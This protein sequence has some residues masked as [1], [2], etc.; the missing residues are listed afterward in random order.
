MAFTQHAVNLRDGIVAALRA[1]LPE[2][3]VLDVRAY[4]GAVDKA[5]IE[6]TTLRAPAV[7]VTVLGGKTAPRGG[8]LLDTLK[9]G[10][11]IVVKAKNSEQRSK[12][13]L[14]LRE[15]CATVLHKADVAADEQHKPPTEIEWAN[16]FDGEVDEMGLTLWAGAWEHVLQIPPLSDDAYD[17]LNDFRT[18]W[19][20]IFNPGEVEDE[21]ETGNAL[22]EQA[23]ELEQD[24]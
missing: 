5:M 3:L 9:F 7:L 11:Y 10:V 21:A 16:L 13:A 15:T 12:A 1:A 17:A 24:P 20:E 14:M 22:T 18:L 2:D 19:S 6:R 4:D 8:T 23:I